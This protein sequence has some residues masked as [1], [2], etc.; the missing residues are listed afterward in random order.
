MK[1]D[2]WEKLKDFIGEMITNEPGDI[3]VHLEIYEEMERLEQEEQSVTW[4]S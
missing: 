4:G 3:I 2:K 1:A